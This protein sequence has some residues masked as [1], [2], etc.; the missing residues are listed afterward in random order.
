MTTRLKLFLIALL[1][2]SLMGTG[3]FAQNRPAFTQQELDRMLAP[4]ALYPDPLLSQIL[5]AATYPIEVVQAAR[6]SRANPHLRGEDAVRAVEPMDWDLS[7]KSLVAFPQVLERMDEQLDW[8]ERLGEAFI[9]QEPQVMDT[10]QELRRRADAAGNLPP[11]EE[12]RIVRE[13]G[14]ILIEPASPYLLYVPYYDPFVVYGAWWW[15]GYRP[16]HWAPWRGYYVRRAYAPGFV[17]GSPIVFRTEFFFGSFSWP[18]RHVT[19]IHRRTPRVIV[20]EETRV[21]RGSRVAP[22]AKPAR[23]QH[24]PR[25]RRGAPF[26]H[27][28]PRA[29]RSTHSAPPRDD[30]RP[31]AS[32]SATRKPLPVTPQPPARVLPGAP[33]SDAG[34]AGAA[35]EGREWQV[36][37]AVPVGVAATRG[38]DHRGMIQRA[39]AITRENTPIAQRLGTPGGA[40]PRTA[41]RVATHN[42]VSAGAREHVGGKNRSPD[43]ATSRSRGSSA[44]PSSG[45]RE[46]VRAKAPSTDLVPS[47]SPGMSVPAREGERER[48]SGRNRSPNLATSRSHGFAS[49]SGAIAPVAMPAP[50]RHL[51]PGR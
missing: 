44:P 2:L 10:I 48:V 1:T 31:E 39:A 14:H 23:W 33:R 24:D 6:W 21:F 50:R 46:R 35:R 49:P 13:G 40:A 17:W 36:R 45:E 42:S 51:A 27:V 34:P 12:M 32:E 5:M 20:H 22:N 43:L 47:R 19:V 30:R 15:P 18:H 38:T 16:V 25:H 37:R 41:S 26:R 4:I 7:V 3:A 9:A 8:T 11:G 28:G 29:S